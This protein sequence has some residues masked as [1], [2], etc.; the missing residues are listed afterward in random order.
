M[1]L[2]DTLLQKLGFR[3]NSVEL[4]LTRKLEEI[5]PGSSGWVMHGFI[6]NLAFGGTMSSR[7]SMGDI[8]PM[9]GAFREGAD[10]GREIQ[11]AFGPAYSANVAALDY[12][13][14]LTNF[15]AQ[16]LGL[17]ADTTDWRE[18]IR[19][20]P[21]AQLRGLGEA[22][23]M[24]A[25]GEITDPRGRLVSDEVHVGSIFAR[26]L[27]FYPL[28]ATRAN[29]AVRLDRMHI[30]YMRNVR[31][32]YILAYA[33]AYRQGDQARMDSVTNMVNEWNTAAREANDDTMLI[34]N[35]R[36]AAVR[37]GRAAA[38]TTIERTS[39]AAPDYSLIDELAE[40]MNADT[41]SEE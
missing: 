39:D 20:M 35:F 15:T 7:V 26:A 27:G 36:S 25:D 9:T 21:Q 29:T 5:M 23:L 30:G 34:R 18:L 32:R 31:A 33:Q 13:G 40:I 22:G 14:L 16:V 2:Y 37:A 17:K 28:E 41:E 6:D 24:A 38:G 19:K 4:Q 11:A 3:H 12:A 10:L 1:D 8:L